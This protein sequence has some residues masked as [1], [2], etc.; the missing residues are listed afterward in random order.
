[1]IVLSHI[2]LLSCL[3]ESKL[4]HGIMHFG[5][6]QIVDFSLSDFV[7]TLFEPCGKKMK[8]LPMI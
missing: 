7:P 2:A 3:P 1:M 4:D 5:P 6:G 8:C